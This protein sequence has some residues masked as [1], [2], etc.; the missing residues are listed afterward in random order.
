MVSLEEKLKEYVVIWQFEFFLMLS[1]EQIFV[2]NFQLDFYNGVNENEFLLV[3]R[4]LFLEFIYVY[5]YKY[6]D[7]FVIIGVY[8]K[9]F[10]K[11]QY[12]LVDF[13]YVLKDFGYN[14]LL[15]VFV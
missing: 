3:F 14:L 2:F 10:S 5:L 4:I 9:F 11:V 15:V 13:L 12:V 6:G 8:K 1:F 7:F